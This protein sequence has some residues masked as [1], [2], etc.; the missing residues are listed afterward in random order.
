MTSDLTKLNNARPTPQYTDHSNWTDKELIALEEEMSDEYYRS[1]TIFSL[2]DYSEVIRELT[3]REL[4][5]IRK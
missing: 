4:M 5:E 2:T 1:G 3:Y